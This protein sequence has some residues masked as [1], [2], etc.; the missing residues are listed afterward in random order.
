M[1]PRAFAYARPTDWPE[2]L[3]ASSPRARGRAPARSRWGRC[4]TCAWRSPTR[5]PTCAICRTMPASAVDGRRAAHR[6]RHDPCRDRGWRGAG[7]D[8]RDHGRRRARHRL[9]PGAQPRHDRRQP[10]PCRSRRPTGSPCCRRWAPRR[11]RSGRSGERRIPLAGFVTRHLRD[12]ARR[13]RAAARRRGAG[14]AGRGALG[15]L[16]VLPQGRRVL[17]GHGLR[18]GAARPVAARRAG[19]ARRRRRW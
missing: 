19:R 17:Q 7:P 15:P 10:G 12:R 11:S 8:R 16:E 5:S 4:S 6:R 18:A 13:R 3:R 1:K 14:A 9:S 2:A